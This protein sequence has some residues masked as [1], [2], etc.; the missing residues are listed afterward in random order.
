MGQIRITFSWKTTTALALRTGHAS[1]GLDAMVRV[2]NGKPEIPGEA[3]KGA[4]REAAERL[5]R[6]QGKLSGREKDSSPWPPP[7]EQLRRIFASD[8][9]QHE[10]RP[11]VFYKFNAATGSTVRRLSVSSTAIETSTGVARDET[12]RLLE[13]WSL[14]ID[15]NLSVDGRNGEWETGTRDYNDLLLLLAAI[16]S[17]T[18]VGG[19]QGTGNGQVSIPELAVAVDATPKLVKND[20]RLELAKWTPEAQ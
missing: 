17:V 15:F 14:G 9:A 4:I 3:V 7:S 20:I 16:V 10:G 1:G 8:L 5:L 6:W 13:Y 19:D 12:L 11:R 18:A 2:R